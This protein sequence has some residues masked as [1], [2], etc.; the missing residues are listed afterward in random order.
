M[1]ITERISNFVAYWYF[2]YILVTA[3]YMLESWER[4]VFS[5]LSR[6]HLQTF[7]LCPLASWVGLT[8]GMWNAE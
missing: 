1:E 5:I 2:Q 4:K 3:L 7:D 6:V 8:C